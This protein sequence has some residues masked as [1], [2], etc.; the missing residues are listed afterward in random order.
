MVINPIVAVYIPIVRIPYFSV[1]MSLSPI[2]GVDQPW[3]KWFL[4]VHPYLEDS[5]CWTDM[6]STIASKNH[7]LPGILKWSPSFW[8]GKD[9]LF[10]GLLF[11]PLTFTENPGS[12]KVWRVLLDPKSHKKHLQLG[13]FFQQPARLR[14][15]CSPGIQGESRGSIRKGKVS[16][17]VWYVIDA[18]KNHRVAVPYIYLSIHT[19]IFLGLVRF[20]FSYEHPW[21]VGVHD[22]CL[23]DRKLGAW[24]VS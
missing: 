18:R 9:L 7:Q 14:F 16:Y 10:G 15:V 24:T 4:Y 12:L 11:G 13:A 3:L 20:L 6:F 22:G 23:H 17:G 21:A 2:Q 5:H 1:W 8:L 19:L